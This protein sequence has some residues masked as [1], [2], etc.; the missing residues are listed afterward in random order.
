MKDKKGVTITKVFQKILD[1]SRHKPNIIWVDKGSEF[2]DR[3]MKSWYQENDIEMYSIHHKGKSVV[4]KDLLESG[5][6]KINKN[7]KY[8]TSISK[9]VYIDKLDKL[10]DIVNKYN[11]TYHST[12]K[13][14][15]VDVKSSTYIDFNKD[16]NKEDPKFKVDDH[17]RIS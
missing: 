9:D 6:N 12:I 3:S 4:L 8:M 2:C 10:D 7:Y 14:K 16:N 17:V 11:N 5:K 13:M 15:P 1:E